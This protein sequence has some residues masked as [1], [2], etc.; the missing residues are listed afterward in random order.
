MKWSEDRKKFLEKEFDTEREWSSLDEQYT[1]KEWKPNYFDLELDIMEEVYK[2]KLRKIINLECKNGSY[3]NVA[4]QQ[5]MN[6]LYSREEK[7]KPW[8]FITINPKSEIVWKDFHQKILS[9]TKWKPFQKGYFVYEQRGDDKE[10]MGKGMHCHMMIEKHS[11]EFKRCCSRL[12]NALKDFCEKPFEN[13]I[14]VKRKIEAHARETLDEYMTGL[15]EKDKM[16]KVSIDE[17]WREELNISPLYNW[18][19]TTDKSIPIKTQDRRVNNGGK[20][21][22]AGRKKTEPASQVSKKKK[23]DISYEIEN[24]IVQLDF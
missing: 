7:V 16:Q 2:S 1:I 18:D 6:E 22:G 19:T 11:M 15:K 24:K 9:I 12:Q 21:V 14:N 10:T 8:F 4:F 3:K 5:K 17:V 23:E 20:R 13:T